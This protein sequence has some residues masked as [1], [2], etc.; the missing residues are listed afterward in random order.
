[1]RLLPRSKRGTW[2]LAAVVWLG[3]CAIIWTLVPGV[4]RIVVPADGAFGAD[5]TA[6]GRWVVA[7][8]DYSN[9]DDVSFRL[10]DP[11][12]GRQVSS[13]RKPN[14][15]TF[16][17]NMW[18][19][20]FVQY[21]VVLFTEDS[22][23]GQRACLYD[24]VAGRR[25]PLPRNAPP[26]IGDSTNCKAYLAV[27]GRY[28]VYETGSPNSPTV[29]WWDRTADRMVGQF[30]GLHL[31]VVKPDGRWLTTERGRETGLDTYVVHEPLSSKECGRIILRQGY[32]AEVWPAGDCVLFMDSMVW[33]L[34]ELPSGQPYLPRQEGRLVAVVADRRQ[35]VSLQPDG[36]DEWLVRWDLATG[37]E[38]GRRPL[39]A[40]YQLRRDTSMSFG[41]HFTFW[42]PENATVASIRSFLAHLPL[43]GKAIDSDVP[44]TQIVYD[45]ATDRE[46]G[47]IPSGGSLS[48]DGRTFVNVAE[49]GSRLE[50]WDIPPRKSLSWLAIAAGVWAL[51]VAWFA[52]RRVRRKSAV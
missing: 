46:V 45:A 35:L 50:F 27:G 20:L 26:W 8:G 31:L 16:L 13:W 10:W 37:Q 47:A 28:L 30:P 24:L 39:P 33:Q 1:M 25:E 18:S 2:A 7:C 5:F 21:G 42:K 3:G 14:D 29:C 9:G 11:L 40:G 51:P 49:Y 48:P 15:A 34:F 19:D 12:T 38:I 22:P 17:L 52:R 36:A 4:P 44:M 23:G 6:N 41:A 32:K 43:I